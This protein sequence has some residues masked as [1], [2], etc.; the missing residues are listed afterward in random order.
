MV[1]DSEIRKSYYLTDRQT[2]GFIDFVGTVFSSSPSVEKM[3]SVTQW[4]RKYRS[5]GR[6]QQ[7]AEWYW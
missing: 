6:Y 2:V 1:L 5:S 7:N 3:H 4:L